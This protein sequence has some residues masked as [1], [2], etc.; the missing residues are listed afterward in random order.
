MGLAKYA[1]DNERIYLE[2]VETKF[3]AWAD[4]SGIT[5]KRAEPQKETAASEFRWW[6][7]YFERRGSHAD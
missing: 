5:D 7:F 4:V 2:R 1:E 6:T 3:G